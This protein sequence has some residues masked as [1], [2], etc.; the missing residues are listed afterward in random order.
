MIA[1]WSSGLAED[2]MDESILVDLGPRIASHPWWIARAELTLTLLERLGIKPPA[3]VLDAGCGWGVTLSAL[4]RGGFRATGLD[5]SRAALERIDA[6]ERSLVEADLT[7][8]WPEGSPTFDAVLALDVIEHLDDDAGAVA[9]LA[10]RLRPGGRL[11][12][13]VPA[14]PE[15]FSEFDAIQGH[16]RRYLPET[17]RGAFATSGLEV[18]QVFWWG[19]WLVERLRRGRLRPRSRPGDSAAQ[20]YRR[21]LTLPPWPASVVIAAMFARERDR[22]LDGALTIGTSLFAVARKQ[23]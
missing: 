11:V 20:T 3:S 7:R 16:R 2:H 6:P 12:V 10:E 21:Y 14:L 13:S 19:G 17:L 5:V 8:P 4:E 18:E 9:R 15:L 22:A 23:S 1:A